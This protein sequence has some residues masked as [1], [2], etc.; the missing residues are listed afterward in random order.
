[1]LIV[2]VGNSND[3][4]FEWLLK[5]LINK[6]N[7]TRGG[8]A[9]YRFFIKMKRLV[10]VVKKIP[11]TLARPAMGFLLCNTPDSSPEWV[12]PLLDV[13]PL[14]CKLICKNLINNSKIFIT[15]I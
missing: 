5:N 12:T 15:R 1:M 2:D 3:I 9:P 10:P 13:L 14:S 4:S 11:R 6:K 7:V 8:D